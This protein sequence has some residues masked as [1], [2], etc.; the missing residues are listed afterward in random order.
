MGIFADYLSSSKSVDTSRPHEAGDRRLSMELAALA[1]L[2]DPT[3][4]AS[5]AAADSVQTIAQ[6]TT[7]PTGGTFTLTFRTPEGRN[8][9]TAAI[10]YN[11]GASTIETAIDV[12]FTAAAYPSW[13][14][15]D[16]SVTAA[17]TNLLGGL[18]TL[19]FDGNSV[20]D[21]AWPAVS[22]DKA[23][24]AYTILNATAQSTTTAGVAAMTNEVQKI[25]QYAANP[26]GGTFKLTFN[27]AGQA[28]VT[29]A[30]I[31]YNAGAAVVEAAIDAA[32]AASAVGA[33]ISFVAS[34]ISV[35]ASSTNLLA[36]FLTLTYDGTSVDQ[37]NQ[38]QA[39]IDGTLLTHGA[40]GAATTKSVNGS[41]TR[42]A[43]NILFYLSVLSGSVPAAGAAPSVTQGYAKRLGRQPS[44]D[45]I[46][47]IARDCAL[48]E[49][50]ELVGPAILLALGIA[51]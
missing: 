39:T 31:A 26:N 30:G 51:A 48:A 6:Y 24:L 43:L 49:D 22:L 21:M 35:T 36:G 3:I 18:I 9:T 23:S 2:G 20:D 16:I 19:T 47:A 11:A 5:Y 15:S 4:G 29:T 33:A 7:N 8:I 46:R 38:G 50:S 27:I 10:A 42:E 44:D 28:A 13:T 17:S 34:D 25:T 1:A 45:L 37:T 12:A 40:F 14:N 32:F 41:A